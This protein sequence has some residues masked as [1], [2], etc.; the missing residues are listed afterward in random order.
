MS[1]CW[2]GRAS[3]SRRVWAWATVEGRRGKRGRARFAFVL[4]VGGSW[5][6]RSLA[7]CW[8]GLAGTSQLLHAEALLGAIVAAKPGRHCGRAC[9]CSTLTRRHTPGNEQSSVRYSTSHAGHTIASQPVDHKHLLQTSTE[10]TPSMTLAAAPGLTT[11]LQT[12][13]LNHAPLILAAPVVSTP[14]PQSTI[15][16][17]SSHVCS[18]P[19]GQP[20]NHPMPAY[21]APPLSTAVWQQ[22]WRHARPAPALIHIVLL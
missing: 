13:C 5:L 3:A 7:G 6:A 18:H 1:A 10:T 12:V 19:V 15:T 20:L 16:A 9:A 2:C 4:C 17:A 11:L 8:Q 14:S 22:S 21:P